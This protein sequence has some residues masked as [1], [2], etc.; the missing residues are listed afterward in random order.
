MSENISDIGDLAV[1][2]LSILK[3]TAGKEGTLS[4][5]RGMIAAVEQWKDVE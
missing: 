4:F 1:R 2:L 5:L 3:K